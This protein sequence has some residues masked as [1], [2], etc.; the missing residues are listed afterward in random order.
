MIKVKTLVNGEIYDVEVLE[1]ERNSASFI[2]KGRAYKVELAEAI[3][4]PASA[5]VAQGS[6]SEP[7][8]NKQNKGKS[9]GKSTASISSGDTVVTA[10][11]PGLLVGIDVAPGDSVTEGQVLI[12]LEAMKMENSIVSPKDAT[13]ESIEV[14]LGDE[15]KDGQLLIRLT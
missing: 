7:K 4:T 1:R 11:I 9:K 6:K 14:E 12:R 8:P 13:I 5:A 3:S 15:V 10:P 2:V